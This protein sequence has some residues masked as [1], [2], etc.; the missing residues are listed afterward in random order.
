MKTRPN[1]YLV[2][3][4]HLNNICKKYTCVI[5]SAA[6]SPFRSPSSVVKTEIK[7]GTF[8]L[9]PKKKNQNWKKKEEIKH[10]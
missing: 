4:V 9:G 10:L 6:K 3:I 5:F 8:Q 2:H 7:I 1:I